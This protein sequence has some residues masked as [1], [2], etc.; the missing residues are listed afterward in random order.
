MDAD[1]GA[2]F[3]KLASIIADQL[4]INADLRAD[5]DALA[6]SLKEVQPNFEARF[7]SHLRAAMS[8]DAYRRQ[9][10]TAVLIRNTVEEFS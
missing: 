3:V 1:T 2:V 10:E 5:V 8:S 7:G 6:A 9:L 4:K